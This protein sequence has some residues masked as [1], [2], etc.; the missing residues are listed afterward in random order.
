MT[1]MMGEPQSIQDRDIH[2]QLPVFHESNQRTTTL[3]MHIKLARVIT[4]I[5]NSKSNI[6]LDILPTNK[7]SFV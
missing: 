7:E 6:S 5:N 1:S 4:E 2:C 3:D